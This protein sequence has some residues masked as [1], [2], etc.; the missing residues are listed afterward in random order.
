MFF[1]RI[2]PLIPSM[3]SARVSRDEKWRA[4]HSSINPLKVQYTGL[5]RC[6][7]MATI[8]EKSARAQSSLATG[9]SDILFTALI[10][11]FKLEFGALI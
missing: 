10:C 1:G 2:L 4:Q 3:Q 8:G 5:R 6:F 11:I 9:E 7:H